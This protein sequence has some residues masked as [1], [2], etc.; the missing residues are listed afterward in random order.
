MYLLGQI[1]YPTATRLR[2]FGIRTCAVLVK[3]NLGTSLA[4]GG[5]GLTTTRLSY[6]C[7]SRESDEHP[8]SHAM[9]KRTAP[10]ALVKPGQPKFG[11]NRFAPLGFPEW[12]VPKTR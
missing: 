7:W 8:S 4:A 10:G 2:R 12:H 11:H 6:L 9:Q 3:R 1:H 5:R